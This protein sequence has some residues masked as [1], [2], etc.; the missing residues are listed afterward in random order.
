MRI[1]DRSETVAANCPACRAA[2]EDKRRRRVRRPMGM[3]AAATVATHVPAA[4]AAV[5]PG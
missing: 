1:D 2:V 5:S 3:T 4:A